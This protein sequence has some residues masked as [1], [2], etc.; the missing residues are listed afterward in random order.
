MLDEH[1]AESWAGYGKV[2]DSSSKLLFVG[3]PIVST[4]LST[5]ISNRKTKFEPIG[6]R[7]NGSERDSRLLTR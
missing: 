2:C 7:D 4:Q 3:V 1:R 6:T 5:T